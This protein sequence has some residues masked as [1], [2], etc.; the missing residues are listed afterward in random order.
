[1]IW[2]D[3]RMQCQA[4]NDSEVYDVRRRIEVDCID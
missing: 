4:K 3:C 2:R 1:M